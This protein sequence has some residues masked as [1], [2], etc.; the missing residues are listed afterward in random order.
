MRELVEKLSIAL[1][2]RG[3]MMA[4][5]ESCTGG[6]IAAAMTDRA[7]SSE[8]FE[9]GFVTYT[10]DS[11]MELLG[12]PAA[13]LETHGAVSAETA[14][15]MARGALQYSR[16]HIAVAVTGIA[17]PS[18]GTPEKPVGL[19]YI[20]WGSR[21]DIRV[22]EHRFTGDRATIRQQTVEAALRHLLDFIK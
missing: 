2:E 1:K 21:N 3:L 14:K 9:R 11:K 12:I 19:V 17:G 16:A 4:A 15:A 13:I 5:A 6:M 20:G 18:G 22:Q 7:G 10:N 8:V